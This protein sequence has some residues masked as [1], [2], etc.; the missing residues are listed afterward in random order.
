MVAWAAGIAPQN[1][2]Q[3]CVVAAALH[4]VVEDGEVTLHDLLAA[5]IPE[6]VVNAVD[7]VTRR[8]AETYEDLIDRAA[9]DRVGRWVKLADNFDN[10]NEQRLSLL[11]PST[12]ERLRA[13]YASARQ[14]LGFVPTKEDRACIVAPW[15]RAVGAPFTSPAPRLADGQIRYLLRSGY[16]TFDESAVCIAVEGTTRSDTLLDGAEWSGMASWAFA[17]RE[18]LDPFPGANWLGGDYGTYLEVAWDTVVR[19]SLENGWPAPVQRAPP[20]PA[21]RPTTD[22]ITPTSDEDDDRIDQWRIDY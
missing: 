9:A 15:V 16:R 1:L 11:E 18:G 20:S 7:S 12:A 21:P 17:L 22:S 4:D 10:S 19:Y 2:Y 8:P 3:A 6:S 5:G 13:K 14:R